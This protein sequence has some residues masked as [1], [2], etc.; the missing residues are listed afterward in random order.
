[1]KRNYIEFTENNELTL[2]R[3]S[4]PPRRDR[5]RSRAVNDD[6][7][8]LSLDRRPLRSDTL[9]AACAR[10]DLDNI[11]S[12][13]E[14]GYLFYDDR[15]VSSHRMFFT[16]N[17]AFCDMARSL[18]K[19]DLGDTESLPEDGPSSLESLVQD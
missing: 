9:C 13:I 6:T 1:M 12:L 8:S 3:E 2:S 19:V 18:F 11:F 16:P 5:E 15:P 17:C 7:I 14:A 10:V 4:T